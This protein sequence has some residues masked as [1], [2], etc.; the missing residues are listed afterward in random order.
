MMD[1]LKNAMKIIKRDPDLMEYIHKKF[2]EVEKSEKNT[3]NSP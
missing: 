1:V 3:V 2:S